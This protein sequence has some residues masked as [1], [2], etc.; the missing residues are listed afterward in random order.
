[1][2]KL[3]NPQSTKEQLIIEAVTL[4]KDQPLEVALIIN[5]VILGMKMNVQKPTTK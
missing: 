3:I 4:L 1:M 5:G 2:R